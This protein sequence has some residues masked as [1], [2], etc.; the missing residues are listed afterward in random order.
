MSEPAPGTPQSVDTSPLLPLPAPD[1]QKKIF[2]WFFFGFFA[3]LLYQLLLIL[4]LFADVIIWA[5]SLALVF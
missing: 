1:A 2:R 4:S 5:C 3:F